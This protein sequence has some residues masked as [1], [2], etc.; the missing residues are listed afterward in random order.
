[1]A[2]TFAPSDAFAYS[3]RL[4]KNMPLED[5]QARLLDDVSK[6]MWMR[7]PWRWTIGH[8]PEVTLVAGQSEYPIVL[9]ADF[10]FL[11]SAYL[12]DDDSGAVRPLHVEPILP[13]T[14]RQTGQ[15]SRVSIHLDGAGDK[16]RVMPLPAD[17]KPG[18]TYRVVSIYKKEAPI[19]TAL[20][21]SN[22]GVHVLDDEW[23]PVYVDG[24]LWKAYLFGDDGRAGSVNVDSSGRVQRTGQ[25]AVFEAGLVTMRETE[26]LPLADFSTASDPEVQKGK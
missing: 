25:A 1:M 12:A 4:I 7:A 26:K 19:I 11:Q 3:K 2:S 14:I 6:I 22:A 16:L 20:N 17:L 8:L 23:F 10:L 24:V 9:P 13:A 5:V 18:T 15:V 21:M